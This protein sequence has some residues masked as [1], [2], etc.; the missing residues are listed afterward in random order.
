M[1]IHSKHVL[2]GS[3]LVSAVIGSNFLNFLFNALLG[4]WL[5]FENFGLITLIITFYYVSSIF[6]NALSGT[7][8]FS[9][10]TMEGNNEQDRAE[11]F[12]PM[13]VKKSLMAAL[14][15]SGLWAICIPLLMTFFHSGSPWPFLAFIP[16][17]IG[18]VYAYA[19]IGY[20]QGSLRFGSAGAVMIAEPIVKLIAGIALTLV[21]LGVLAYLSLPLSLVGAAAIGFILIQ[22]TN[23]R[24][25]SVSSKSFAFPWHFFLTSLAAGIGSTVFFS[26]DIFLVRHYFSSTLSGQYALVS[27]IGKMVYFFA[28][29]PNIFT[30]PI[31]ARTRDESEIMRLFLI[32]LGSTIALCVV[33]WVGLVGLGWLFVPLLFGAKANAILTLLPQYV[34][35]ISLYSIASVIIG[36]QVVKKR[37]I[38]GY[39]S[40]LTGIIFAILMMMGHSS[41][42]VVISNLV[43]TCLLLLSGVIVLYLFYPRRAVSHAK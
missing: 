12:Y 28:V 42:S 37:Y 19:T 41:L 26:L 6:T 34:L 21:G 11:V 27:L 3:F 13:V 20:F 23:T 32:V 4:R 35:G 43:L 22:K 5:S 33:A 31:V 29:L 16:I 7:I 39:I 36:F 10:S 14:I 18:S 24:S 30:L 15:G 1:K 25:K 2:S 17:L 8:N 9:V 38:F 40:L